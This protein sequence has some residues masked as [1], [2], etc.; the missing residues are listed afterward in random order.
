MEYLMRYFFYILCIMCIFTACL[1]TQK[2]DAINLNSSDLETY[3]ITRSDAP[4]S[5][6]KSNGLDKS[7][8]NYSKI[9]VGI[10]TAGLWNDIHNWPFWNQ[11]IQ[12]KENYK[13]QTYWGIYP[14]NC[15]VIQLLSGSKPVVDESVSLTDEHNNELWTSR[16]DVNG[17]A[18]VFVDPF[19]DNISK[20]QYLIVGKNS[21]ID[22]SSLEKLNASEIN[23]IQIK[24]DKINP[25]NLDILFI[26]DATAS[27]DDEIDFLKN[28]FQ[29]VMNKCSEQSNDIQIRS[30]A[31]F[32]RDLDDAFITRS[33]DFDYNSN[34]TLKFIKAQNADG[35]GDYPE[36]LD[37]ALD[38]ALA[39]NW[40]EHA[41]AR[42]AFVFLDAPAHNDEKS[43]NSIKR[44]IKIASN[45]GINLIPVASSGIDKDT[46]FLSR[47]MSILTNGNYL[48]LTDHSGIGEDHLEPTIGKYEIH[49][50]NDLLLEVINQKSKMIISLNS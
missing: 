33:I 32:Y 29:D 12:K 46:E 25:T 14:N 44:Q 24:N 13:Y 36:A 7:K 19:H 2:P 3:L 47:F 39:L 42:I 37:H 5:I 31:V 6:N 28:E 43:L 8:L 50:L 49:Y 34:N 4:N 22:F 9:D 20:A 18:H 45:E 35:G 17:I 48:F 27:M 38:T 10:L 1:E 26:M 16:T 40:S 21:K 11:L 15:Y 41:V 23:V 30:A